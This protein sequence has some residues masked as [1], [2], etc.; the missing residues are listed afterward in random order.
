MSTTLDGVKAYF[1]QFGK[2]AET[3]LRFDETTHRHRCF[4][5]VT[6]ESEESANKVCDIHFHEINSKM[7]ECKKEVMMTP[8]TR[9]PA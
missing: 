4:A 8:A 6:F 2:I 9:G 7:V 3:M 1:Q 5:F